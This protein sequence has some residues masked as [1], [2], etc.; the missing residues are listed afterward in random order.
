MQI[1]SRDLQFMYVCSRE[2]K[3]ALEAS[4]MVVEEVQIQ[5]EKLDCCH[6][7]WMYAAPAGIS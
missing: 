7:G 4:L 2:V 1:V 6:Q 3:F 5:P